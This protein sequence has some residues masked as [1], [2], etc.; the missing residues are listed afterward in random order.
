MTQIGKRALCP[1]K[2]RSRSPSNTGAFQEES[3][4]AAL[5][6]WYRSP[7]ETDVVCLVFSDRLAWTQSK[8]L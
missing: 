3:G 7:V 4:D 8:L 2:N 6:M 1:L 5:L